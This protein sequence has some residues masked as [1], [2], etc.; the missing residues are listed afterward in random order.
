MK[1][2]RFTL[3]L[4]LMAATMTTL[5][6]CDDDPW[7]WDYYD[8][9]GDWYDNY[10]WYNDSFDYGT[11][12]LNAL[13]Q[14]LRGHWTG[15]LRNYYRDDNGQWTYADM[16]VDFEFDQYDSQSLNGRGREVDYVGDEWQELRFSWYIDPR[17]GNINVR[18]D[19]S[20]YTFLLDAS[21]NEE[22]AGFSLDANAFSGVMEG[23]NNDEL[24]V[25][26]CTR[27][28][29]AKTHTNWQDDAET[30]TV[31][32]EASDTTAVGNAKFGKAARRTFTPNNKMLRK[33]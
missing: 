21:A 14:T 29:L 7:R 1:K 24:L 33:R 16:D 12:E 20:G 30:A 19:N 3:A 2:V 25:F 22:F 17:T 32:S 13:A 26:D 9:Y 4:L 10:D 31:D 6:S 8:Y 11:K 28:T 18:Y 27:T 15:S 23:Q 5:T